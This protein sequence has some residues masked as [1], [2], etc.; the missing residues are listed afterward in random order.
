MSCC[1]PTCEEGALCERW[2]GR[3]QA[4]ITCRPND[5][6]FL[7]LRTGATSALPGTVW[8]L[9][10]CRTLLGS[11]RPWPGSCQMAHVP[12][13]SQGGDKVGL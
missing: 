2:P 7:D 3:E 10:C 11:G 1:Q 12:A 13:A 4:K 9:S 5:L 6:L 8:S